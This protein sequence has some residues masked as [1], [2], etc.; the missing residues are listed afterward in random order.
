MNAPAA[1]AALL[2]LE[3]IESSFHPYSTGPLRYQGVTPGM[4]IDQQNWRVAEQLLPAEVLH[5]I[6]QGDFTITVQETT[7]LP[8]RETYIT[9][10]TEQFASVSLDSGYR[11]E[12]YRGGRPFP[13]LHPTDPRAGEKAA[14]NFHYR[15]VPDTLEMRGTMDGVTDTGA[16]DRSS[17]GRMRVRYGMDRVGHEENDPQWESQGIRTKASF[18]A[19]APSDI[20]GN[21]RI[22]T[23]YD[24]QHHPSVD[25]AYSPQNRRTRKSYVN[26]IMR[27]GG[28]RYDVLQEE[29]PPFFF[30]GY[31]HDYTW[32]YKGEQTMLA[33]GFLRADHLTF[34][35]KNNWYPN[36]PWELRKVVILESTPKGD[37]PY[38]KRI[39][40][41]DAQT[42]AP[43]YVL[44]YNPQGAFIRLSL[45]VHGNP[46]FIPGSNGIRLPVPLGATWVNYSQAHAYRMIADNPTFNRDFSPR[47]FELMELL[48]KG[49]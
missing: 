18:E 15:D 7:D 47:R 42:Y 37:H 26:M 28:G 1:L 40:Y 8:L 12:H 43:F 36:T 21:M 44:S 45:I 5:L 31:I 30:S 34:G 46:G 6:Q 10:T 35:G 11:I 2:P 4:T 9:A 3:A 27:M 38:S 48:R 49:K 19:L 29:Q 14:W 22:T 39:F 17:T 16:I 25:F 32:T 41:L 13:I 23:Y 33:P 20:E 24:D